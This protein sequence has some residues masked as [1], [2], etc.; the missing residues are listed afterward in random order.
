MKHTR[1]EDKKETM[2]EGTKGSRKTEVV[3]KDWTQELIL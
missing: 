2:E 1:G 3:S